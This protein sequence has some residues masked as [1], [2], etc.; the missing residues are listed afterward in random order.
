[1][2]VGVEDGVGKGGKAETSG[3]WLVSI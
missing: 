1:M 3:E 2:V